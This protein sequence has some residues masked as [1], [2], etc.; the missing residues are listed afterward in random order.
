MTTCCAF[1]LDLVLAMAQ[2]DHVEIPVTNVC[3]YHEHEKVDKC[4]YK[5]EEDRYGAE[6]EYLA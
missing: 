1:W 3:S 5:D 4:P 2:K 6:C